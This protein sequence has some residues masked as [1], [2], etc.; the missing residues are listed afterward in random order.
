MTFRKKQN[1]PTENGSGW[2]GLDAGVGEWM[3]NVTMMG[4]REGFSG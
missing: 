4:Q 2:L 1:Y 3:G